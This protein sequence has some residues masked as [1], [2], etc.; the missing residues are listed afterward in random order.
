MVDDICAAE[1]KSLSPS[2]M[3]DT[4]DELP[5]DDDDDDDDK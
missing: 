2:R 1:N 5:S 3:T 4:M